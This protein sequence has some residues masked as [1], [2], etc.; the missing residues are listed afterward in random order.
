[1]INSF[2]NYTGSKYRILDQI[3][4]AFPD[5]CRTFIDLFGGSGVVT[6]NYPHAQNYVF[7]D[8]NKPLIDLFEYIQTNSPNNVELEIDSIIR[9]FELTNTFKMGYTFYG[10][11]SKEGL[12][13]INRIGYSRLRNYYNSLIDT[14]QKPLYLYALILFAFNNQIR[15]NSHGDFNVPVGK[16]D[17]NKN[18]RTK[19]QNFSKAWQKISPQLKSEDFRNIK[20]SS[21]DLIY[22]DPPYLITTAAYNENGGWTD[23]DDLELMQYLDKANQSGVAFILSNVFEH[24]GKRNQRLI[25]WA[26]QYR[27]ID[28]FN[29]FNNSNYHTNHGKSREVMVTNQ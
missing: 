14:S 16:R 5:K 17:F 20:P 3:L 28:L 13:N 26:S 7:N 1:M 9:E 4:P 24:K 15:F 25:D 27:V 8:I 23:K 29:S 19:L 10:A 2:L 11:S 18:M 6:I 21:G 22:A 12:A